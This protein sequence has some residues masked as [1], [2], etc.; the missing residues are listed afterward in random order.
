MA[1]I[2]EVSISNQKG[3]KKTPVHEAEFLANYGMADDAHATFGIKRQVSLLSL[4]SVQKMRDMGA[5][6]NPGDFAENL[7]VEGMELFTLP[8]G[9]RLKIGAEAEFVVS[10]IGKEC[11]HG[12]EI[13]KQVGKCVMP[14]EGIFVTVAKGGKVR[15]G[16]EVTII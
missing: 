9:T 11:H 4:D 6:V 15:V 1:S 16:D 14:T 2:V 13:F 5:S 8:I 3:V 7:T 12:C 10:Q